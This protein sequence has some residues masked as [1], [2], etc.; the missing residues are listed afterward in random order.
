MLY[1]YDNNSTCILA[2][3]GL[4]IHLRAQLRGYELL[5]HMEKD[6]I[7]TVLLY[8]SPILISEK[9]PTQLSG[10]KHLSSLD[11]VSYYDVPFCKSFVLSYI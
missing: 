7:N 6:D 2:L 10:Q 1:I 11:H 5:S 4:H 9:C 8:Y 3:S